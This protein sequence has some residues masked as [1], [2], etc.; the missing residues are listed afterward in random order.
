MVLQDGLLSS[1]SEIWKVQIR[2]QCLHVKERG[3]SYFD[4]IICGWLARHYKL[5]CW[6]KKHQFCSKQSIR[7]EW[8]RAIKTS[9]WSQNKSKYFENHDL[10]VQILIIHAQN[11]PH[12]RLQRST[13]PI[14]IWHQVRGKWLHTF[15]RQHSLHN[16]LGAF[17][18]THIWD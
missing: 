4:C 9:H 18:F 3:V 6:V 17:Y 13:L 5:Y 15:G 11:I 8:S 1:I 16:S 14:S 2:L 10:I 7:Y 12:G